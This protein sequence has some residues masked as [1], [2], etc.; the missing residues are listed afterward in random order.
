M[1]GKNNI[2]FIGW[3]PMFEENMLK[4]AQEVESQTIIHCSYFLNNKSKTSSWINIW[5]TTVLRH[6][7]EYLPMIMAFNIPLAPEKLYL[8]KEKICLSFSIVFPT[9]PIQWVEFDLIE[10]QNKSA[11]IKVLKIKRNNKGIYKIII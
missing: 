8:D 2:S 7:N 11:G 3:L 1:F 6:N 9:I 10:Q 5:P 4:H